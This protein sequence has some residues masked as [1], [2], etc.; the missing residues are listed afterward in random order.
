MTLLIISI[1]LVG[2]LKGVTDYLAHSRYEKGW[3]GNSPSRKYKLGT[4]IPKFMFSTTSLVFITDA[5]HFSNML[6]R[7]ALSIAVYSQGGIIPG[8]IAFCLPWVG[9]W[10]TYYPLKKRI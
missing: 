4:T 7:V 2:A 5:W 3:W 9:F 6:S 1:L 8:I 10:M